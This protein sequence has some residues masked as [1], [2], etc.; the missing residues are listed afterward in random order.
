[1]VLGD[2]ACFPRRRSQVVDHG[3]TCKPGSVVFPVSG[4]I[5]IKGLGND[6]NVAF[7]IIEPLNGLI[8]HAAKLGSE[9]EI[10]GWPILRGF[11]GL[12]KFDEFGIDHGHALG[13]QQ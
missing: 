5:G 13:L 4:D 7:R 2:V 9:Q 8:P 10:D 6:C 12:L 1:M 11:L 3:A